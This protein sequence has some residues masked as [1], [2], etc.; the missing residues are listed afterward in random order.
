MIDLDSLTV[1]ELES[2][3]ES[4]PSI[5]KLIKQIKEF[6]KFNKIEYFQPFDYQRTFMNAGKTN[7]V[8]Y[9]RAG[10]RTGK[11]FGAAAEMA[12]HLTGLYPD[13]FSGERVP[14]SGH[15]YWCVGVT[16]DSVKNVLQKEILGTDNAVQID[17]IGSGSIPRKCIDFENGFSRDGARVKSCVIKHKDGGTNTLKFYGS[18]DESIMI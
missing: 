3:S 17:D 10:N 9:L 16:L 1:E 6:Q 4:L 18:Q 14:D 13:W 7:K 8:R 2:I 11:T 5:E 15:I 12:Y